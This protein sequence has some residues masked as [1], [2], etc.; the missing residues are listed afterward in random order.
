MLFSE[1]NLLELDKF[2]FCSKIG[3]RERK[4]MT[5]RKEGKYIAIPSVCP[6]CLLQDTRADE[7]N[8]ML[9]CKVCGCRGH[10]SQFIKGQKSR[11][12]V[13]KLFAEGRL[14]GDLNKLR[15]DPLLGS[16]RKPVNK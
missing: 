9:K 4:E 15:G 12:M 6:R 8:S 14:T 11:E 7:K 16:S 3:C 10:W 2:F 1:E 5:K 13:Q